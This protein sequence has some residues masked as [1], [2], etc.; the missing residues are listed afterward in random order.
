[1]FNEDKIRCGCCCHGMVTYCDRCITEKK[2]KEELEKLKR[3][4]KKLKIL[5]ISNKIQGVQSLKQINK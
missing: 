5:V 3:Q 1:M 2:T 4:I